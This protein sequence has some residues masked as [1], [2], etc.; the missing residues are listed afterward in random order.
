MGV[1][2]CDRN[3]K[4]RV[5]IIMLGWLEKGRIEAMEIKDPRKIVRIIA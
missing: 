2:S 4:F 3:T 1:K 5:Q